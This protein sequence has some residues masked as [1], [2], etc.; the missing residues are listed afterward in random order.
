MGDRPG[1]NVAG[2]T[3]NGYNIYG[4]QFRNN[5]G[6]CNYIGLK[7]EQFYFGDFSH[8]DIFIYLQNN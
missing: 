4:S 8:M 2:G 7:T 3:V 6:N 5:F 1:L